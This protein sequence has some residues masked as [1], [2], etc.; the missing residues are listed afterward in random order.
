MKF[1]S[2]S[3]KMRP[4]TTNGDDNLYSPGEVVP[5]SG[6]FEVVGPRG[7]HREGLEVTGVEGKRLP[8]TQESG[9]K[10]K[11]VDPTKHKGGK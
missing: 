9:L 11:P 6:Q 8:P 1:I 7:G 4:M 3:A 10:Y 2:S 5:Q